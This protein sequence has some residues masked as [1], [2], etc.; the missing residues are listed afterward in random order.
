MHDGVA[1]KVTMELKEGPRV[2]IASCCSTRSPS[3]QV[4][5]RVVEFRGD[6]PPDSRSSF[7]QH[8]RGVY[9]LSRLRRLR[10]RE[11]RE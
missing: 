5:A 11:K 8:Q 1:V 6:A 2:G 3:L 4:R 9:V 10:K 7:L